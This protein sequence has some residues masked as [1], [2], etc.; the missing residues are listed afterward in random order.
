[1]A[2]STAAST[3]RRFTFRTRKKNRALERC[4][5]SRDPSLPDCLK[6]KTASDSPWTCVSFSDAVRPCRA[7]IRRRVTYATVLLVRSAS[8]VSYTSERQKTTATQIP[9]ENLKNRLQKNPSVA[10]SKRPGERAVKRLQKH[11]LPQARCF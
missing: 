8:E 9:G 10:T 5:G 3:A 11:R 1:M 4:P 7:K 6:S 2:R